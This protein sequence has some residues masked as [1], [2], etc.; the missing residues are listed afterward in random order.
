MSEGVLDTSVLIDF[1]HVETSDLPERQLITVLTLAELSTGPLVARTDEE[2]A[3]RQE[4]LQRV[5]S[6]FDPLVV[7]EAAARSFAQVAASLR[8]A[9]RKAKARTFDALIAAI[10]L[11]N[12]LP[13]YTCNP[14]DFQHIDGL[15]VIP[16]RRRS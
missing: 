13:V 11:A 3:K 7:D 14:A 2:R 1:E 16:I 4:R 8:R 6:G 5:E 15:E 12:G 10:A 9:G